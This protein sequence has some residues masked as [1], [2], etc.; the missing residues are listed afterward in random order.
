MLQDAIAAA[1]VANS[2]LQAMR[3]KTDDTEVVLKI[4]HDIE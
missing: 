3:S 1:L 4:Q 2:I